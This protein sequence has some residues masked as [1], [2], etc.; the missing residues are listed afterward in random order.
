LLE[1]QA[2]QVSGSQSAGSGGQQHEV[3]I[4]GEIHTIA[5][6]FSG[7]GCTTS[8]RKRYAR[9]IMSVEIFED[10]LPDVDITFTKGDLRDVVPHDNDPI[11][12]SLVTAGRTVSTKEVQ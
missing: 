11:V 4:H 9:S 3:P 1:K 12:I 5:G 6:G 10:H 2:D 8:Q 7:D